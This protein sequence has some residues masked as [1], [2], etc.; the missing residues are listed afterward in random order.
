MAITGDGHLRKAGA[1]YHRSLLFDLRNPAFRVV[2]VK[3]AFCAVFF[4]TGFSVQA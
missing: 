3:S 4:V 2:G 1:L